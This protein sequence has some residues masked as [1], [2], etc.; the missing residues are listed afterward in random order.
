[1]ERALN[2]SM[3]T[4]ILLILAYFFKGPVHKVYNGLKNALSVVIPR[5]N[6]IYI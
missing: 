3:I 5:F 4:L 6:L 1:M 2:Y